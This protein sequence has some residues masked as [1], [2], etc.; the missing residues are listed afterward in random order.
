MSSSYEIAISV[1][2]QRNDGA[3]P[4][5]VEHGLRAVVGSKWKDVPPLAMMPTREGHL[6]EPESRRPIPEPELIATRSGR[7]VKAP[8]RLK[9]RVCD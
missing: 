8:T 4:E 2:L 1:H 7:V 6:P 3:V 9:D 5:E